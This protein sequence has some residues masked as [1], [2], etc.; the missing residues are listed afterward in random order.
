[1]LIAGFQNELKGVGR[2]W[3]RKASWRLWELSWALERIW[4]EAGGDG[5]DSG[6][7]SIE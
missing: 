7:E 4:V 6:K 1:M 5:V 2:E 3:Q